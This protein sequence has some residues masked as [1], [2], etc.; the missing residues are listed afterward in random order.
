MTTEN[1]VRMVFCI[2]MLFISH[3]LCWS[4][5]KDFKLGPWKMM[6][7]SLFIPGIPLILLGYYLIAQV[8]LNEI[9]N[10]WRES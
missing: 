6:R 3:V 7:L 9:K 2:I 10:T 4:F 1:I 8:S 5:L